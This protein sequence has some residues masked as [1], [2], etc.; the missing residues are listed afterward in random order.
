MATPALPVL[1]SVST[2]YRVVW[3][4]IGYLPMAAALPFL[5]SLLL[6]LPVMLSPQDQAMGMVLGMLEVAPYTLFAV[7]W[8]RLVMLGPEI[9]PPSYALVWGRRHW[10]FLG[11]TLAFALAG[12]VATL[13]VLGV[14]APLMAAPE[15]GQ[16]VLVPL[17][18]IIGYLMTRLCLVLPAAALDEPY[19]LRHSWMHT[20]NQGLRLLSILVLA[21]IPIVLVMMLIAGVLS[22]PISDTTGGTPSL[23]RFLSAQF[24]LAALGYVGT[25]LSITVISQAFRQLAGWYPGDQHKT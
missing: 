22:A 18:I 8:H 16:L 13:V 5:L 10:R 14:A 23:G 15:A 3:G 2:A 4:L 20:R 12:A 21:M 1:E 17:V 24:T 9:A 25:A 6:S 19:Q 11:Y 7:T